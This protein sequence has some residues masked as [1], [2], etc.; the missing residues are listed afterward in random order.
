[1]YH[2]CVKI[3]RDTVLFLFGSGRLSTNGI[4]VYDLKTETF[5]QQKKTPIVPIATAAVTT[6]ANFLIAATAAAAAAN[7]VPDEVHSS[8]LA[9]RRVNTDNAGDDTHNNGG[10]YVTGILPKPKFTGVAQPTWKKRDIYYY[11]WWIL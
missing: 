1:V 7:G 6:T 4:I 3:S 5:I 11:P 8:R 2:N 10:V 9:P